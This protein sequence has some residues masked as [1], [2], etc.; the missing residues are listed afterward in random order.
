MNNFDFWLHQFDRDLRN[1]TWKNCPP[2]LFSVLD[3]HRPVTT[4]PWSPRKISHGVEDL[5][6]RFNPTWLW[7]SNLGSRQWLQAQARWQPRNKEYSLEILVFCVWFSAD[8]AWVFFSRHLIC[9]KQNF[10]LGVA[11]YAQV[12][13]GRKNGTGG[14]RMSCK[15]RRAAWI[16]SFLF[17]FFGESFRSVR[18]E[19]FK[20]TPEFYS[21]SLSWHRRNSVGSASQ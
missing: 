18:L 6:N 15:R 11:V 8:F 5:W 7:R 21:A 2:V 9:S 4:G 20:Q 17:V 12:Q 16:S 10:C 14:G 1:F 3:N 13:I 19:V